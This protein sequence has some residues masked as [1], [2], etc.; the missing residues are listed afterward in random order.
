MDVFATIFFFL[1]LVL[2]VVF[3]IITICR[4]TLFPD[5]WYLML[6]HPVQSLYLGCYPMGAATLITVSVVLFYQKDGVGG[7]PFYISYGASGG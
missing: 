6:R 5:V 1:N 4:F 2:F 3:N 7:P